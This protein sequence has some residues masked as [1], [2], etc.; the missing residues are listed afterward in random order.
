[1]ADV[2]IVKG[3]NIDETEGDWIKRVAEINKKQ[4][5]GNVLTRGKRRR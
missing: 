4:R 2:E 1:M 5:E 3:W